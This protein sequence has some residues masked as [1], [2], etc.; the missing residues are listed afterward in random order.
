MKK[1]YRISIDCA[2][3]A[4]KLERAIRKIEGVESAVVNFMTG[5]I[6]LEASDDRISAVEQEMLKTAK[7]IEPDCEIRL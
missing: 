6:T 3:C 1:V 5:K 2:G 4:A 7:R